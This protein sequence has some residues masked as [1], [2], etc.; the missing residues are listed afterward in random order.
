MK[1][2]FAVILF[3]ALLL[4]TWVSVFT[5]PGRAASEAVTGDFF[6]AYDIPVSGG[7]PQNIVASGAG[8]VWF[9]LPDISAVGSLV[10]TSTTDFNFEIISATP[11]G[12]PFDLVYDAGLGA[13]WFTEKSANTIGRLDIATKNVTTY[14]IPTSAS[15]PTGIDIAPDGTIWYVTFAGNQISQFVPGSTTFNEFLYTT[16]GAEFEDVAVSGNDSIWASSPALDRLVKLRPTISQFTIAPVND[17]LQPSWPPQNI[18]MGSADQ[19]WVAAPTKNFVGFLS[20][21]TLSNWFWYALPGPAT[22]DP[23][24]LVYTTS[25]GNRVVWYVK[26]AAGKVGQLTTTSGGSKLFLTEFLLDANASPTGITA[27]SAQHIW[28]TAPGTNQIIEWR[29]PYYNSVFLPTIIKE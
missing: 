27:D 12:D 20:P 28:I 7:N 2:L 10:V 5:S 1:K 26:T 18:D 23:T 13:I 19:P 24:A 22:D 11:N 29:P 8:Q 14:T 16:A 3:S 25:G 21:G 4:T 17:I 6:T 9:T 15:E